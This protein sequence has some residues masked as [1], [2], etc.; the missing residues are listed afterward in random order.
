MPV[1]CR[2]LPA[3]DGRRAASATVPA[4]IT[5]VPTT[6]TAR[7]CSSGR[8]PARMVLYHDSPE[9]PLLTENQQG[10]GA[11]FGTFAPGKTVELS[12]V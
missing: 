6:E 5:R 7:P 10:G 9:P 12:R 2:A 11:I 8:A 4:T 1:A 3:A